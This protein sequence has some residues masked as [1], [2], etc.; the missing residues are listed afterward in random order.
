MSFIDNGN[1]YFQAY[2]ISRTKLPPLIFRLSFDN[3]NIA[4]ISYVYEQGSI[5][6]MFTVFGVE[7][8]EGGS[9]D[10]GASLGTPISVPRLQ[11]R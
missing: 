8:L 10:R 7:L 9:M 1:R 11:K 3:F 2:F 4:T 5:A 6:G